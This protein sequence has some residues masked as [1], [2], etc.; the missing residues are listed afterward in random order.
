MSFLHH[1]FEV[2]SASL[3]GPR[4]NRKFSSRK[5]DRRLNLEQMEARMMMSVNPIC[6]VAIHNGLD[7]LAVPALRSQGRTRK[8]P[9]RP[10]SPPGGRTSTPAKTVSSVGSSIK[11]LPAPSLTSTAYSSSQINLSWNKVSGT[12]Y[13]LVDE[14][15]NS[16]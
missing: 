3:K 4:G 6:N 14:W 1:T 9:V 13:Y 5:S 8:G 12:S 2:V 16:A 11:P 10:R 15:I 7:N